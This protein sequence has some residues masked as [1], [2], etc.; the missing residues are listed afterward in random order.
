MNQ[1]VRVLIVDDQERTRK[2]LQ[3]MLT[4]IEWS[5]SGETEPAV[6]VVAHAADGRE[7]LESIKSYQPDVVLMDARMPGMDGLEATRL[8]KQTWPAIRV[9]I[10][11][12]YPIDKIDALR[13]GADAILFKGG[14][15]TE[16]EA[17]I[18]N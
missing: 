12:M 7:A 15:S 8:I 13:A 9:V 3:A 16:L 6:Q 1:P 10:L 4:S 14:D 2:A 11:T 5:E 17:A 18:L